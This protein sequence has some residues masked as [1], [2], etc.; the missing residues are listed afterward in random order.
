[1]GLI[2]EIAL[3]LIVAYLVVCIVSMVTKKIVAYILVAI[4]LL[5]YT[6]AILAFQPSEDKHEEKDREHSKSI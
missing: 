4:C 1:M 5:I 6:L 3:V 2:G